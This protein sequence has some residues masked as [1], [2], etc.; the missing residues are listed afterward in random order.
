MS[1]AHNKRLKHNHR[2]NGVVL[3]VRPASREHDRSS[4]VT[5]DRK[6]KSTQ[7]QERR[8]CLAEASGHTQGPSRPTQGNFV[9]MTTKSNDGLESKQRNEGHKENLIHDALCLV[10]RGR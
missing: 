5:A 1:V 9:A 6:R 4:S 2:M 3:S 10:F 7:K 8:G